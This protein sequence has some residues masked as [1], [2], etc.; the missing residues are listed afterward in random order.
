MLDRTTTEIKDI[1]SLADSNQMEEARQG[2]ISA[3]RKHV[4]VD[5]AGEMRTDYEFG[6]KPKYAAEHGDEPQTPRDVKKTMEKR[7]LYR[8]WSSL[9]YNAQEMVWGSVQDSVE[10]TLP[11]MIDVAREAAETNPA[12]GIPTARSKP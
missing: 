2:F 4:M 1:A 10:R 7:T 5:L 12:G 8:F 3:L 9:R 6:A 11:D